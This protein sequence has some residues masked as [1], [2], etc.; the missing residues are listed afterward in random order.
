MFVFIFK[1]ISEFLNSV[2]ST[3]VTVFDAIRT[4]PAPNA[5]TN[6]EHKRVCDHIV[7]QNLPS[8][9][10]SKQKLFPSKVII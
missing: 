5:Q 2:L 7:K 4:D 3:C 9:E 8:D 1:N 10:V 6:E